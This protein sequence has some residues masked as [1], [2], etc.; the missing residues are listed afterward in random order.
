MLTL[1]QINIKLNL[2]FLCPPTSHLSYL[3]PTYPTKFIGLIVICP[4]MLVCVPL[5]SFP[6][7]LICTLTICRTRGWIEV[8]GQRLGVAKQNHVLKKELTHLS[9]RMGQPTDGIGQFPYIFSVSLISKF[10]IIFYPNFL[11][12]GLFLVDHKPNNKWIDGNNFYL[13]PISSVIITYL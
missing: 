9:Q 7:T 10:I 6:A 8:G 13:H 12:L 2:S 4:C 1:V 3:P 11:L 5:C